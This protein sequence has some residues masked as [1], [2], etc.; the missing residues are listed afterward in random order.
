M[1]NYNGNKKTTPIRTFNSLRRYTVAAW[2]SLFGGLSSFGQY[3]QLKDQVSQFA[4]QYASLGS[5]L[6]LIAQIQVVIAFLTFIL[7]LTLLHRQKLYYGLTVIG[8]F[9]LSFILAIISYSITSQY[10][11]LESTNII[12]AF[13]GMSIV[14]V[15]W[16]FF[17]NPYRLIK[18]YPDVVY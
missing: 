4:S 2:L 3:T 7:R 9:V 8:G 14:S 11:E 16:L 17:L 1:E 15:F 12:G 18:I 13:M 10:I 5:S 6:L